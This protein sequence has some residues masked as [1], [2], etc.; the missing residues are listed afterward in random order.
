MLPVFPQW[1][2][3]EVLLQLVLLQESSQVLQAVQLV[4]IQLPQH[5]E[6]E[7]QVCCKHHCVVSLHLEDS[8]R[9]TEQQA[10]RE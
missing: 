10:A 9:H 7:L 4:V 8:L 2:R 6:W 1:E 5:A 3:H